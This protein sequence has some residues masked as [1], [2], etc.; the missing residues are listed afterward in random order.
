MLTSGSSRPR[1]NAISPSAARL[2]KEIDAVEAFDPLDVA[3]LAVALA[4]LFKGVLLV[5]NAIGFPLE[6]LVPMVT[7]PPLPIARVPPSDAPLSTKS[8]P[9]STV[10][11]PV[12]LFAPPRIKVPAPV[13]VNDWPAPLIG[14]EIESELLAAVSMAKL[15]ESDRPAWIEWLPAVTWIVALFDPFLIWS[16]PPEPGPI[17]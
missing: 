16:E 5:A 12:K 7:S 4:T 3:A 8:A 1:D 10:V 17:V 13:L 2:A 11:P 14:P 15:L 6:S 9:P